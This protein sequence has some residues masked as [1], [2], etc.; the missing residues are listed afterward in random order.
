MENATIVCAECKAVIDELAVFPGKRC[1][2]C[3]GKH[4]D[5]LSPEEQVPNFA[6]TIN[7]K[8]VDRIV[9]KRKR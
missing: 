6:G 2:N 5:T 9:R 7:M 3:F 1:I 8:A 4:F